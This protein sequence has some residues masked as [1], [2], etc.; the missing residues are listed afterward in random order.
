MAQLP[1]RTASGS[2]TDAYRDAHAMIL[3]PASLA[4]L[5]PYFMKRWILFSE[6]YCRYYFKCWPVV[7]LQGDP[8]KAGPYFES[9]S[10]LHFLSEWNETSVITNL[11][12]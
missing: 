7:V 2:K 8:K 11:V 4:Y 12:C 1:P 5:F 3:S 10:V 6:E 9:V